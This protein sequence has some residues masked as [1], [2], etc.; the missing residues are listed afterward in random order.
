MSGR[1]R[2]P[3]DPRGH[4]LLL[5]LVL[6]MMF[7]AL[8]FEG[9]TTHEVDAARR[10]KP[11]CTTPDTARPRTTGTRSCASAAARCQT[12]TMPARTAALTFDGGPDPVWTPRLLDLLRRHHA[13]ATFFLYG[14]EAAR[15]PDLVRRIRA[16]GHE[17]G[18]Y[19]YTGGDLGSP[20]RCAPDWN[21][22]SRRRR[23]AGSAGVN[24]GLLRLPHTTAADTLC[25]AEWTAAR[26]AADA[27]L[28]AGRRGPQVP[29][30]VAR[31]W[32]GS[33][34]R[35]TSATARPR[36]CSRNRGVETFTTVTAGSGG[37]RP[38]R[39]RPPSERLQGEGLI[40]CE[41]HRARLRARD[42]LGAGDRGRAGRPAAAAARRSSPGSTC[43]G[44]SGSGPARPGCGR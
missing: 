35:P 3:R 21:C 39:R 14:A 26:R 16:E 34:A 42:D 4:W 40:W 41:G 8:L 38:P 9:W 15:H 29:Q 31:A 28:S 7:A 18:S 30:A 43:G 2:L 19:T 32:C 1:H 11:P 33:T 6:P 13:H 44:C 10:R 37:P 5:I 22:R 27:G 24:T 12:A 17:I 20:R 25:G 36:S 23:L